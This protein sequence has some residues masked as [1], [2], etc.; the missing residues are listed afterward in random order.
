[1]RLKQLPS[2]DEK[3]KNKNRLC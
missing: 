2:L 3:K 1:M